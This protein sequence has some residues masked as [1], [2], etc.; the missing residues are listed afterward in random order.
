MNPL[1]DTDGV[2]R[3]GGRLQQAEFATFDMKHPVILPKGHPV[4]NMLILNYNEK[5]A[6]ANRETV[7]NELR[8]RFHIPKLRQA[9]RQAVKGCMWCRVNR[10]S[11]QAP[12]MAP[13][14]VQRVTSHLR[15]FS[16]VGVDYLG[17]I[18][19]S[20]GRRREKRWIALFTCLAV[21]AVHLKVVHGL[22]TQ[23]CLMAIRRFLSKRGAPDEFFSDNGT[24]FKGACNE[25]ACI[26][27]ECA[28]VVTSPTIKWTFIPPATP[29]MGGSWERMVRS[30]SSSSILL[31]TLAEAEDAI[32]TRPLVYLPQEAAEIEAIT[33]N[34]F[35]RGT[36][37]DAD[38]K[39]DASS[40]FAEALRD[41]YKRSQYLAE[42]MWQ[43]WWKEYLPTINLR[44]KWVEDRKQLRVGDLVFIVN[45]GHR[46]NWTR[47]IVEEVFA[48]L[49]ATKLLK[50]GGANF[51][52]ECL[53]TDQIY[54]A[55]PGLFG[56]DPAVTSRSAFASLEA[57][58][59]VLG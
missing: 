57:E 2:M 44:S 54:N 48:V 7:C 30:S 18:E 36:I 8:Q 13:L 27:R 39:V 53:L 40:D 32:N 49:A 45:D 14:P 55:G 46:K 28:G 16:S 24:N 37:K 31:T 23:A 22:S 58:V 41:V 3:V 11:P 43:R 6:H 35:L 51:R 29:H 1:L 15:P 59:A 4:T 9:I 34:H 19:V 12:M 20:V 21:R 10:C 5:F 50:K 26:G 38:L 42:Q 33:P 17:P 52:S 56:F 47:G 25:L